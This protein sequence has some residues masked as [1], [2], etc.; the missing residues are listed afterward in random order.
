MPVEQFNDIQYGGVEYLI[1]L[2]SI[3]KIYVGQLLRV[4]VRLSAY[5]KR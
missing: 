2:K 5:Y 1:E 4:L 3:R